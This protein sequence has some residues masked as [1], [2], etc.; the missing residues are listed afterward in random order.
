VKVIVIGGGIGGLALAQGLRRRGVDVAVYER[1]RSATDRL[2]GYRVHINRGGSRALHACLPPEV[3]AAFLATCGQPNTGIGVFTHRLRELIWFGGEST[4]AASDPVDGV[5]SASRI[6]LR[7]V[8]LAGLGDVVHF[9]KTFTSYQTNGAGLVTARFADGSTATGDVL[10]GADGG[11]SLVRR[12]YLPHADRIDTG[13]TGIQ[14][15]VWL[16]EQARALVPTRMSHGPVMIPGP[17]GLGMFLAM[18]EFQ[19]I[20]AELADLVGPE[21]AGQRDYIMWGLLTR[22]ANLPDNLERLDEAGLL[23]LALQRIT[24]WHPNLRRL[25]AA[26]ALD[27]VLLTP[28]RSSVPVDSWP[29]ST[30]TLL[31]DAIHSMPPTGGI[32][33]NTA[34]RDAAVLAGKL[35]AVADGERVLLEAVAEYEAEMRHYGFAAVNSSLR[36]LRRQQR[37]ENPIALTGMKIALRALNAVA[38]LKRRALTEA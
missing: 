25:V 6:S 5:K 24:G 32:G 23:A 16:T 8:L 29:A 31:G 1:D 4:G 2:Q 17:G 9:D 35:A 36:N 34:L 33:A 20:P 15:K 7:Q 10:V 37:A 30:V 11:G 26:T 28:I 14:G 21:A 27:T 18:H 22:R 19:P 38:P 3:F 12:Q 13:V